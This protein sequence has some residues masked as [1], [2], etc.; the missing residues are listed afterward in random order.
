MTLPKTRQLAV[1]EDVG[2]NPVE[3]AP[4]DAQAQIAFLLGGEAADGGAVE[5]EVLVGTSRNFLS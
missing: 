4:V 3:G 5:G 2:G 1:A